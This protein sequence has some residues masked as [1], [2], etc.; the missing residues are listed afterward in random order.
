MSRRSSASALA[1]W[2]PEKSTL[3]RASNLGPELVQLDSRRKAVGKLIAVSVVKVV[4][5]LL[6]VNQSPLEL[7]ETSCALSG[8]KAF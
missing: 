3:A 1:C 8:G 2:N 4:F 6:D 7:R 5:V